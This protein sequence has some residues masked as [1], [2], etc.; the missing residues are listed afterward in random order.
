MTRIMFLALAA[1]ATLAACNKADH[2]IVAGPDDTPDSNIASAGPVALP[3]SITAT[4]SY[5][6]GNNTVVY[7]N[8]MSDGSAHVKKSMEDVGT[9]IAPGSPALKGDAKSSSITYNGQECNA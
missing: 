5:R 8:W 9:A 7:V 2:T 4:K 6:C 1:T 3:P